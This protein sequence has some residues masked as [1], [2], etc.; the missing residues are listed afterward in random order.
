M[1]I[2]LLIFYLHQII[3]VLVPDIP[4][5]RLSVVNGNEIGNYLEKMK[6]Y[7]AAQASTSQTVADKAWMKN[8]IHVIGGTDSSE[9]D[10]FQLL[11]E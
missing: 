4:V 9:N 8:I 5:G 1:V 2:L 11:Y 10:L 7:E 3:T 6:Q